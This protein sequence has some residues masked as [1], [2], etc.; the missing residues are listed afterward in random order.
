MR[1]KP[2][3][4]AGSVDSAFGC[5]GL[6]VSAA[7]SLEGLPT[8]IP[9][10]RNTT[11]VSTSDAAT[12]DPETK[13]G[14]FWNNHQSMDRVGYITTGGSVSHPSTLLSLE[15]SNTDTSDASTQ[16][17]A[18]ERDQFEDSFAYDD[19]YS[20]TTSTLREL[21]MSIPRHRN[22][23]DISTSHATQ[24]DLAKRTAEIWGK[25]V[26]SW[27]QRMKDPAV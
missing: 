9:G 18:T 17:E 25:H 11:N 16:D 19:P 21:P 6:N 8:F 1:R 20:S 27:E 14:E 13:V 26:E 5:V 15:M 4:G 10:H 3:T 22:T 12:Q 24:V 23:T 2:G 7:M